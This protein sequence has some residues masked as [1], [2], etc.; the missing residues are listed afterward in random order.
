MAPLPRRVYLTFDLDFFDPSLLPA[1]G[2]PEPGGGR[3]W[4]TLDLLEV[5]FA[6]K[7]VV[8]ADCV[9]L[10]PLP[11]QPASDFLAARLVWKWI[12]LWERAG[13]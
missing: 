5:L 7:E 13:R 2:T 3:W 11:G 6:E 4:P 1:T 10:A 12:D 8:A 9:E